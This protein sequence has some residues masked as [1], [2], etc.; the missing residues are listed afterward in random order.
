M[1]ELLDHD[2]LTEAEAAD[3]FKFTSVRNP[4]DSLVSDYVKRASELHKQL[5]DKD[6]WIHRNPNTLR[7]MEF[8]RD[9]SFPEWVEHRF[10]RRVGARRQRR[11]VAPRHITGA[12]L[13][14][15]DHVM[16]F[17]SLQEDFDAVCERLGIEERYEIPAI[18]VTKSR[19]GQGYR[20]YYDDRSRELVEHLHA[21]DLER[22]GYT[23]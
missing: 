11:P 15:I 12:Q 4:F 17:E 10:T 3:L 6:S 22:F 20:A 18:H 14:G 7:D 16:R 19:E 1:Q 2:Q 5:D 23:F 13:E 21:P 9:H 8:A